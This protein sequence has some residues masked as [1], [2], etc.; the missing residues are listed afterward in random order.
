MPAGSTSI[1]W[2][3]LFREP[4]NHH[5][6]I[7]VACRSGRDKLFAFMHRN[8]APATASPHSGQPA[9]GAGRADR[10]LTS[11]GAGTAS[12]VPVVRRAALPD[13]GGRTG[14]GGPEE[15][16]R[17]GLCHAWPSCDHSGMTDDR[18]IT[19]A[20]TRE[21]EA[22]EAS[23]RPK[24]LDEYLGQQAVREQLG[25]TSRR[26]KG[27]GEALD[28]VLIFGP[29]RAGEDHAEPRHRQR[30]GRQPAP[31]VGAGDREGRRPGRAADQPAGARRAVRR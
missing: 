12:G 24:R 5:R 21:D 13:S 4:R 15:R 29:A 17:I 19:T 16:C 6:S 30:A 23:I 27:R 26:R 28:H 22:L 31:D 25:I 9:G 7:T 2:N 20:S 10:N 18:L 14:R 3:H 8:A 1:R 11:E